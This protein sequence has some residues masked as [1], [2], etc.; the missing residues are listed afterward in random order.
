MS[1]REENGQVILTMSANDWANLLMALG[2]AAGS[3]DPES[4][5]LARVFNL[6]NRLNQGNPNYR[7]YRVEDTQSKEGTDQ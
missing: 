5:M 2:I 1:C 6:V 3:L 4:P 7:S